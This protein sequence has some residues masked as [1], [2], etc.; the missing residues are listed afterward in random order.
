MTHVGL[1]KCERATPAARSQASHKCEC[2]Q[3]AENFGA[4]V[5]KVNQAGSTQHRATRRAR[6]QDQRDGANDRNDVHLVH[7]VDP[8]DFR[9]AFAAPC[10]AHLNERVDGR[11]GAGHGPQRYRHTRSMRN[12]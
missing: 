7:R 9:D 11:I 10:A 3:Q 6:K 8:V 1:F 12:L 4:T 5:G 2:G